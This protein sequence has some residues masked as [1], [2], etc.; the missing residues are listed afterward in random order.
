MRALRWTGAG[1][2]ALLAGILGLVGV[3]LCVTLVLMPLGI[4]VLFLAKRLFKTA[5]QLAVPRAVRRPVDELGRRGSKMTKKAGRTG[6]KAA[7]K[8]ADAGSDGA[9]RLGEAL[10]LPR[11]SKT[12]RLRRKLHLA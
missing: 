4:P 9:Q 7:A 6:R 8:A 2:L 5:G 12:A 10:P 1:L 11:R 3:I